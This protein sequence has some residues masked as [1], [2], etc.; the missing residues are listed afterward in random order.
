MGIKNLLLSEEKILKFSDF[1][2]SSIDQSKLLVEPSP[3]YHRAHSWRFP[4]PGVDSFNESWQVPTPKVDTFAVG[5]VL[6]EIFT[7]SLLYGD[8]DYDEIRKIFTRQDYPDLTDVHI[9]EVRRVIRK[10]WAE[11]YDSMNEI[12]LDMKEILQYEAEE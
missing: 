9:P 5:T 11:Q 2:G 1:G 7:A 12:C 4:I 10:C 3:R 6:Y 8:K